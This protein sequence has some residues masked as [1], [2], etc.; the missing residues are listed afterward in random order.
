MLLLCLPLS[1]GFPSFCVKN[2]VFTVASKI[3]ITSLPIGSLAC[4]LFLL[5]PSFAKLQTQGLCVISPQGLCT[6]YS[7]CLEALILDISMANPSLPIDLYLKCHFS[8]RPPRPPSLKLQLPPHPP[9]LFILFLV[10]C[11]FYTNYCWTYSF[12]CSC[13]LIVFGQSLSTRL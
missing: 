5:C 7:F 13:M 2:T 10:S 9:I 4:L 3:Y 12:I 8:V 11:F 6:G 1:E